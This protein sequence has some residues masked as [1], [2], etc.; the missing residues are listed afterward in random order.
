M[1]FGIAIIKTPAIVIVLMIGLCI[2]LSAYGVVSWG[3]PLVRSLA[4][5]IV[6]KYDRYFPEVTFE[7]GHA[8]IT[9]PQPYFVDFGQGKKSPIVI[10]TREGSENAALEYLKSAQD[11]VVLTR[12]TLVVKNKGQI[13]IVPLADMPNFVLNSENIRSL[14]SQYL[15]RVIAVVAIVVAVYFLFSKVLQVLLFAV[16]PLIWAQV[17]KVSL[18]YGQAMKIA[19]FC[20][21]PPVILAALHLLFHAP[22]GGILVY[23]GLYLVLVIVLS[24]VVTRSLRSEGEPSA[25]INP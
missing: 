14:V 22:A 12:N 23:F 5:Q 13:R 25:A 7:K 18:S 21:V 20:M 15:P 1:K 11:G 8:S 6:T 10:D 3:S 19:A 2:A 4:N 24:A 9:K 16:I 17:S